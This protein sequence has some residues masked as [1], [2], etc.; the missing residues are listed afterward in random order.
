MILLSNK[1]NKRS[2]GFTLIELMIVVAIISILAAIAFPSYDA[3]VIRGKRAE[4]KAMLMD[5]ASKLE[6]YYGDCLK[7]GTITLDANTDCAANKI[8][9]CND[10]TCR[11]ET[12]KY[13]LSFE[14]QG[15]STYTVVATH[16]F[17]DTQC[18]VLRLKHTGE[19]C[20]SEGA[21]TKGAAGTQVC[22]TTSAANRTKVNDCWGR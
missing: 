7:F 12:R 9:I 14:D 11:S 21:A 3:Y 22:S 17:I 1:S 5:A 15:S 19:K 16:D 20:I 4:G 6:K 8:N 13:T 2:I 10:T 18:G